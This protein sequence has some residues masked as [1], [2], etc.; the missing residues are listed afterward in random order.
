MVQLVGVFRLCNGVYSGL[1]LWYTFSIFGLGFTY[2]RALGEY[3]LG[4]NR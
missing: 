3:R 2:G 4:F 1:L